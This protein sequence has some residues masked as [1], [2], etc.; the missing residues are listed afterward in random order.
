MHRIVATTVFLAMCVSTAVAEVVFVEDFQSPSDYRQRW[1]EH[2]GWRLVQAEI[3]GEKSTVLDV[4]GGE[5]GLGV[6]V[7]RFGNFDFEADFRIL[8]GYGGFVFRAQDAGNL[9]MMQFGP[10]WLCPHTATHGKWKWDRVKLP[11]RI[12]LGQWVHV[13]CEVRGERF[14]CYLGATAEQMKLVADWQGNGRFAAGRIGFRCHSGEH[15]QVDHV[16]VATDEPITAQLEVTRPSPPR[17]LF[18]GSATVIKIDLHNPGWKAA[19]DVRAV[20]SLP[21][22]FALAEGQAAQQIEELNIGQTQALSWKIRTG[23]PAEGHVEI[24][25]QHSGQ[26]EPQ[27]TEF[28]LVAEAALPQRPASAPDKA[29][30]EL[31]EGNNLVLANQ[32]VRLVLPKSAPGYCAAVLYV[33]DGKQWRQAAVSQPIGHVAYQTAQGQSLERDIAP[34]ACEIVSTGGQTAQVCLKSTETDE[35]GCRWDFTFTYRLDSGAKLVQADYR[36]RADKDRQLLYF[37]GP[38][39][40]AGE[41]SFGARKQQAIFGGL[42]WLEADERSSSDRDMV[43][44][45][46][47][48]YAPHPYKICMPVMA[49]ATEEI[50]VGLMW[51][52]LQKWDGEHQQLSARFASP[53]WKEGQDNHLMGLFLPSVPEYVPENKDRAAKPYP[54]KAGKEICLSASIVA[55][56]TGQLMGIVDQ[57]LAAFGPLGKLPLPEDY[58]AIMKKCR[59]GYMETMWDRKV[60]GT[61]HWDGGPAQQFPNACAILWQDAVWSADPKV[62]QKQKDRVKLIV[63]KALEKNGPAG[64]VDPIDTRA[65]G[66]LPC[67][68]RGYFLPLYVG[69]LEA[70]LA[71]WKE[72]IEKECLATQRPDGSW[73]VAGHAGCRQGEDIVSGT[74]AELAGSVLMYAR[75]TGDERALKAGL[76][77]LEVL[78]KMPVPRGAQVW[79][80]PKYTPDILASGHALW[81]YLEAY[82][83]TG[84]Q[85]YLQRARYWGKTVFPFVY[86]WQAPDREIMKYCTIAVLGTS[87]YRHAWFGR[88]V[89]WCGLVPAYWL[90]RLGELDQGYPWKELGQGIVDNGI[91]QMLRVW[92]QYPGTYT[93]SIGMI[94]R[95]VSPCR[96]EPESLMKPILLMRGTPV[97]VSTRIVQAEGTRIHVS[98]AAQLGTAEFDIA[99]KTLSCEIQYPEDETSYLVIAGI[100]PSQLRKDG[101]VLAQVPDLETVSEGW[102]IGVEGLVLVKL[103]HGRMIVHLEAIQQ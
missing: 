97:E 69:H 39:L 41:G 100:A 38:D 28:R 16:R 70:G 23:R 36:A 43:P 31:D 82:Q 37:Q 24:R 12:A 76:K 92:K 95:N 46:A 90:I 98:T 84:E 59:V 13:K 48:R 57:Y 14:K 80:C 62:K 79:E 8:D 30:A 42:E 61:K 20:L 77:A 72:R 94:D 45:I 53:N 58:D 103:R 2:P 26:T 55:E 81:A 51:D 32:H 33:Y 96:F 9:Y 67:H 6:P 54:L 91:Q 44:A 35:D 47:N 74:I 78:D 63:D 11:S 19:K 3:R 25:V 64:L 49:I 102:K 1:G 50:L 56:S 15:I 99:K 27:R 40:Y 101:T 4:N 10:E 89:Q 52:P 22:G 5:V 75:V 17:M 88:P 66:T 87:H 68:I 18:A 7:F 86:L 34:E 85:K 73:P 29:V 93:D 21:A 71:A 83:I 65:F 60:V